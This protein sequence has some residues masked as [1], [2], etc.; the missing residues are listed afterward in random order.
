MILSFYLLLIRV[1]CKW[2]WILWGN[3]K[4]NLARKSKK[5]K[6]TSIFL[7]K[8]LGKSINRLRRSRVL[9]KEKIS[10]IYLGCPIGHARKMKS[11]F[12][13]LIKKWRTSYKPEKAGF[14]LMGVRLSWLI[15]CCKVFL[16]TFYLLLLLSNVLSMNY[17]NCLL[18]FSGLTM[19]EKGK[20]LGLLDQHVL[21]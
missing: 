10:F 1:L 3:M 4:D 12:K 9:I 15:K 8:L 21:S 11:H 16:F 18:D 5:K 13:E 2:L 20:A 7:I 19:R 14:Y 6:A 17:T